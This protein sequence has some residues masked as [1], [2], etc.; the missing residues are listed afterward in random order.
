MSF[1]F[2][3]VIAEPTETIF[4]SRRFIELKSENMCISEKFYLGF[5]HDSMPNVDNN[6]T[7]SSSSTSSNVNVILRNKKK[8]SNLLSNGRYAKNCFSINNGRGKN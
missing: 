3:C 8:N 2:F 7:A 5:H 6:F 1:M 4:I